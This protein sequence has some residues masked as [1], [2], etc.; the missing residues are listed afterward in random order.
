MTEKEFRRRWDK[1]EDDLRERLDQV[2][3]SE[4]ETEEISTKPTIWLYFQTF[5]GYKDSG[6]RKNKALYSRH[7]D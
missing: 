7:D 5:L 2:N 6:S 1:W 4:E 3:H